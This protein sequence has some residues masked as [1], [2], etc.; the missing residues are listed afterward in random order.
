MRRIKKVKIVKKPDICIGDHFIY[1]D[2]KWICLD[3][4]D[5]NYLAITAKVWQELPFDV[6]DYNNWKE[7]SL[8]R[9]LNDEFLGKLNKKHLVKQTSDLIADNGDKRYGSCEDYV[10]IL[11]C[12]QYRKYRDLVPCYIEWMWTLTPGN[13]IGGSII[14]RYVNSAGDVNNDG[15]CN[16]FGVAP[17]C[18]FS[19]E[20]LKSSHLGIQKQNQL[21]GSCR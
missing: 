5:G 19:S 8:R 10:T 12:D 2:I 3:I 7:S 17:V 16:S 18:L 4:I 15:A 13:C 20:I 1:K 21:G 11:S 14:V 9:V 6:D